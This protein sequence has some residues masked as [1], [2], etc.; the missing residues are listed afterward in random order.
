MTE[1]PPLIMLGAN[2]AWN[3]TN[4]RAGLIEALIARGFRVIAVAP[5]DAEIEARLAEL[6]CAFAPVSIDSMGLSPLRDLRS[7]A[8]LYRL[9]RKHRPAAWL[10]W[11]IKPNTY[12]AI[13]ARL[14]RVPA[15]PNVSGLGTAFIAGGLLGWLVRKLYRVAFARATTVFFQNGDDR[16]LFLREGMAREAQ[17][18]LLPGSGID[19]A[20]WKAPSDQRPQRRQFLMVARVVADKGVREYVEAARSLRAAWP[21][22]RFRLLGP[23]EVNNRTAI[24]R[25]EVEAWVAE[26]VITY[27]PPSRD[28]RPMIAEADVIVL[29]SYRE[30][31]SRILLEASAMGRPIV[32]TDVPGCRDV[33]R[34]G[35]SGFLCRPRDAASLALAMGRAAAL[36]DVDWER[37]AVA[38]RA[39]VIAEFSQA[40]VTA[41]YLEALHAAGVDGDAR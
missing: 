21:D 10:S 18:R 31:L 25:A 15:L 1:L 29:P 22:A 39:R 35:E 32:T 7:L 27:L 34:D 23:L 26:G 33:V 41:L 4:F 9:M 16:A 11:T 37:M 12:G 3:L 30:G 24:S 38:G 6:G 2:Q 14:C 19:A 40:R 13:A 28:V 20:V 5:E 17:A 36:S 8:A